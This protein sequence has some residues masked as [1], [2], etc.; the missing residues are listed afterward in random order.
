MSL[1]W[2]DGFESYGDTTGVA[3]VPYGVVNT[4]YL[5]TSIAGEKVEVGF[6]AKSLR[7]N[8]GSFKTPF[9]NF[10]D[11]TL[12]VGFMINIKGIWRTSSV[13]MIEFASNSSW[14]IR[15]Y[16]NGDELFL[17]T[18]SGLVGWSEGLSLKDDVWY[19]VEMKVKCHDTTGTAE[20]RVNGTNVLSATGLDTEPG[21]L[22]YFTTVELGYQGSSY[23][24]YDNLY[25]CTG[26]G[27]VNNDFLGPI[28]VV[29]LR[30]DA[31]YSNTFINHTP[32]A[33]SYENVD[34]S[35]SD[36]NTAYA[37]DNAVGAEEMFE[38]EALSG[39]DS[40]IG[41]ALDA[42][43][44]TNTGVTETFQHRVVSN[45][46]SQNSGD[47]DTDVETFQ[48]YTYVVEQ[49]PDTSA[50]WI[51]SGVNAAKFGIELQ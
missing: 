7:L 34:E 24:R 28:H 15:L 37:Q 16:T 14:G 21:A 25:I 47:V 31:D 51:T 1:V 6:G 42:R 26:A 40:V 27:S 41:V 19:F 10:S 38:Y 13:V 48:T 8:Y 45:V 18:P 11:D 50:A 3:P 20:V 46:T 35:E 23:C 5:A 22:G 32:S 17:W 49:D 29:E 2:L 30:P 12:I 43:L 9:I 36:E 33:F 44:R 4:K 39:L